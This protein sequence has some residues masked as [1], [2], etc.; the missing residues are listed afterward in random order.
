MTA[1]ATSAGSPRWSVVL[2]TNIL[3]A[4][5]L[6]GHRTPRRYDAIRRCVEVTRAQGGLVASL[7]TLAEFRSVLLRPGF[8]RYAPLDERAR[9]ADAIATESRLVTPTKAVRLCRD[10]NDDMFLAA[11]L[12]G[13]AGW[14]VTVDRQLL[15][16]HSIGATRVL[17]PERFLEAIA[18]LPT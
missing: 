8:D 4:A 10:P 14:L 1:G 2:D 16:V 7:E 13:E 12:A 15:S 11:A 5:A 3:V 18:V 9:F 6:A 17:R